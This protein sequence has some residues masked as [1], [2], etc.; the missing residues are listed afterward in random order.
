[1]VARYRAAAD[2][3][4]RVATIEAH[5][6]GTMAN[7]YTSLHYHFAFSTKR[8]HPWIVSEIEERVWTYLGGILKTNK[9]KPIKIGGIEDHVHLLLGAPPTIAPAKIVQLVKGGSSIW[10]HEEFPDLADFAW[11]DGYGAFTVSKSAVPDVSAY[12]ANQREHHRT[13]TYQEEF[14]ALLER[15]GIEFDERYLWD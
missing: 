15:H 2:C 8:R 12:I 1:M 11:Q 7:T 5:N 13:R 10:I 3:R 14:R 6:E 9:L 4:R